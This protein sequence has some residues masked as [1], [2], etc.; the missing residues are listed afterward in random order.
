MV[1]IWTQTVSG[2]NLRHTSARVTCSYLHS[3]RNAIEHGMEWPC[4]VIEIGKQAGVRRG[5]RHCSRCYMA[6]KKAPRD[7]N[8]MLSAHH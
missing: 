7:A 3:W 5:V 2:R 6:S 4:R 8:A 1:M